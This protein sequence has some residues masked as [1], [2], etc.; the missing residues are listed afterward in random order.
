MKWN[1]KGFKKISDGVIKNVDFVKSRMEPVHTL[2]VVLQMDEKPADLT[3]L[4]VNF[5]DDQT[6]DECREHL[7]ND[8]NKK[9]PMTA[10]YE[11][12]GGVILSPIPKRN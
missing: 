5:S 2:W 8:F 6:P 12:D 1:I 7:E 10:H 9:T 4:Y 11:K 3:M